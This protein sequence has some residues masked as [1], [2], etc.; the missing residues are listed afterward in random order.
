[1]SQSEQN[2]NE[3]QGG[4]FKA[5]L[6]DSAANTMAIGAAAMVPLVAMVGASAE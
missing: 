5:L 2:P 4:F 3:I 1:M 6:N